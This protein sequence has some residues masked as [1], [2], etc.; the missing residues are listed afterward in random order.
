MSNALNIGNRREVFWDD[1]LIDTEKTTTHARVGQFSERERVGEFNKRWDIGCISYPCVV[2]TP[3]GYKM[4]YVAHTMEKSPGPNGEEPRQSG[5][6]C[7]VCVL[8]SKDG[9][10]WTYPTLDNYY[11]FGLDNNVVMTVG[12]NFFC[13][14][15]ENPDCPPEERY[16][17]VVK[18]FYV[19]KKRGIYLFTSADGYHFNYKCVMTHTGA[20]DTL[21]TL[22]WKD[23]KYICYMRDYHK[24]RQAPVPV[25]NALER[26]LSLPPEKDFANSD[27]IRGIQVIYSEDGVNW[28][29]PKDINFDDGL[30]FPMYTNQVEIYERAPHLFVGFPVRYCERREWTEN[31]EQLGNYDVRMGFVNGK[32]PRGGLSLTDTIFMMSRDG[33]M[34]HRYNQALLTAGYENEYNWVYGDCYLSYKLLDSGAEYYYMYEIGCHLNYD[35]DI[36]PP[37][38]RLKIRKDGFA[39]H[40][41]GG[42]EKLLVTKPLIF[43]GDELHLNFETSAYGYV[44]VD[45]LDEDGNKISEGQSFEVFGNNI[46]RRVMFEDGSGFSAFA[47]KPVRLRFRMRDAKVYSF[48]FEA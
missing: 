8:D 31:Y 33:E 48:K 7:L 25:T 29:E 9:I 11:Y 28:T 44:I 42:E 16:K 24:R 6:N 41:A 45:V 10:N 43:D 40:A 34:W 14:Y 3:D 15:D 23:G 1:Y 46:D 2:K 20:F 37:L 38:Y 36:L 30:D 13:Y 12:D 21:N 18:G 47:G 22:M 39:C 26:N 5:C 35:K 19:D 27:E 17:A 4:Y 32:S